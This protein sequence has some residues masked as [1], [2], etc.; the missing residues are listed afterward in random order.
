[1]CPSP[2][3]IAFLTID[4]ESRPL[5]QPSTT[6]LKN[7]LHYGQTDPGPSVP[8][9]V[10]QDEGSLVPLS[11]R[12]FSSLGWQEFVLPDGARYFSNPTLHIVTDFD[13]R[14]TERLDAMT[15][16][17]DGSD[18]EVFPPKGWELWLRDTAEPTTA[19]LQAKAW[20]HHGA[21]AVLLERPSSDTGEEMSKDVDSKLL[22]IHAWGCSP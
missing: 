4:S 6:S 8:Y 17:L 10:P 16:L 12:R 18:A 22:A 11:A 3:C 21:R 20:V 15:I 14:D 13:L 5:L 19:F 9:F 1:M 2:Y 7:T